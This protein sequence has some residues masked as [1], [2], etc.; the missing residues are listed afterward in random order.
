[1]NKFIRFIL[2]FLVLVIARTAVFAQHLYHDAQVPEYKETP[3]FI[4]PSGYDNY[5]N[6]M[7]SKIDEIYQIHVSN[8]ARY[9]QLISELDPNG[10]GSGFFERFQL[11]GH[12]YGGMNHPCLIQNVMACNQILHCVVDEDIDNSDYVTMIRMSY[13]TYFRKVVYHH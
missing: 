4:S 10:W 5:Y 11:I 9:F 1:L 7:F 3:R 8:P 12:I 13:N 2:G 6:G